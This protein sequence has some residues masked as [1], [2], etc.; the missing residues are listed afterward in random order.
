MLNREAIQLFSSNDNLCNPSIIEYGSGIIG[1]AKR[2]NYVSSEEFAGT[3]YLFIL[4][5]QFRLEHFHEVKQLEGM[6]NSTLYRKNGVVYCLVFHK[7]M[8]YLMRMLEDFTFTKTRISTREINKLSRATNYVFCNK[9]FSPLEFAG[10]NLFIYSVNPYIII[11]LVDE[12]FRSA[13]SALPFDSRLPAAPHGGTR[14][15]KFSDEEAIGM[16]H[17]YEGTIKN[18]RYRTY[19]LSVSLEPPYHPL[20]VSS[21]PLLDGLT[22]ASDAEPL[23]CCWLSDGAKIVYERGI[24]R[25]N[26]DYLI[27]YG[28]QDKYAKLIKISSGELDLLLDTPV[29]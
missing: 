23:K 25:F 12:E 9:N 29:I 10:K 21:K 26:N 7:N 19:L 18:R 1:I 22:D 14:F 3:T 15:I 8:I 6:R 13:E 27:S 2:W 20:R 11:E 28:V 24:A 16:F 17:I 4:D 5:N